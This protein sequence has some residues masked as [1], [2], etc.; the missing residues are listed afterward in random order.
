MKYILV[1][2]VSI[3]TLFASESSYALKHDILARIFKNISL[4]SEIV[5]WCDDENLQDEFIKRATFK[6]APTCQEASLVVLSDKK[7]ISQQ[8]L[9]KATFVLDYNLLKELPQSFG[10]MFWKKARPNIIIIKSRAKAGQITISDS[11]KSYI[12][13][14]IW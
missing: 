5:I 12:E 14:E 8:C 6:V 11:L 2:I 10:A 3:Y 13:D 9:D 7:K 4:K 1:F